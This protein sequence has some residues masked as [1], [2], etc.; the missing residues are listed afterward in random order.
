M[1]D[2]YVLRE[3]G[4]KERQGFDGGKCIEEFECV[5]ARTLAWYNRKWVRSMGRRFCKKEVIVEVL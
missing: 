2:W 3:F 5:S 4:S 1:R